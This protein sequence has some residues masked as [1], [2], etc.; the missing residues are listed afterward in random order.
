M[1]QG[2]LNNSNPHELLR[3]LLFSPGKFLILIAEGYVNTNESSMSSGKEVQ[4]LER[5]NV[6]L[7]FK[8]L[9]RLT[10]DQELSH[11]KS[12]ERT[13]DRRE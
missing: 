2:L 3:K 4:K 1:W 13:T 11:W 10:G 9:A 12:S 7:A 5:T 6:A 8:H